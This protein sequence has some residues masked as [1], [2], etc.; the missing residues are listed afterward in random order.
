[1]A[2]ASPQAD[3]GFVTEIVP[4][5]K[6]GGRFVPGT[7]ISIVELGGA[8]GSNPEFVNAQRS[9]AP[10]SRNNRTHLIHFGDKHDSYLLMPVSMV[11]SSA[12]KS[13]ASARDETVRVPLHRL[14]A[15]KSE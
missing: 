2:I 10:L 11:S 9:D 12:T 13:A 14:A 5:P 4:V 7:D 15:A 6:K 1:M 8:M 3:V